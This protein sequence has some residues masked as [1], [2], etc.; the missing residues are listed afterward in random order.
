M[1]A[2]AL[3]GYKWE[4]T[5]VLVSVCEWCSWICVGGA[6]FELM[7]TCRLIFVVW[8][9]VESSKKVKLFL[10]YAVRRSLDNSKR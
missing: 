9:R 2:I 4:S 8:C 3:R 7:S 6:D 10:L 5:A 1:Q